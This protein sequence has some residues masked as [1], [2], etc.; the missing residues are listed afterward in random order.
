MRNLILTGF[1]EGG[2]RDV[3]SILSKR[4]SMPVCYIT[5]MIEAMEG[6]TCSSIIKKEGTEVLGDIEEMVI[7]SAL[8]KIEGRIV[9]VDSGAVL[10]RSNIRTMSE[11][12][13]VFYIHKPLDQLVSRGG[14]KAAQSLA[15]M[16]N[17]RV[18]LLKKYAD[19]VLIND[20]SPEATAQA[21]E[22]ALFASPAAC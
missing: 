22:T 2:T 11:N 19:I 5:D 8:S 10:R 9:V 18:D 6:R 7:K 3:A 15:L 1:P 21:A 13:T 4:L 14:K 17:E 16:Y 20:K 12:G